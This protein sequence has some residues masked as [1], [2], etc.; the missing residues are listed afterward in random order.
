MSRLPERFYDREPL[1]VAPELLGKVL[2]KDGIRLRITEV[3]AYCGP[4]D[5]AA[6]SR[7]GQT[8]RNAPMWG[9]PGRVY[10]YVCYGIHQML[11]IVT[12]GPARATAILVRACE[13]ADDASLA[14][15]SQRRGGKE[16]PVLLTGPG[17]VG[18]ALAL[19]TSWSHHP[20]FE[21]GGLEL[22]E[23]PAPPGI[24]TGARIGI[25]YAEPS[26]RDAP[27]R[28]AAAETRWVSHLKPL[29]EA[30]GQR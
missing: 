18:Q 27:W 11:N 16:G 9:P 23:G 8:A 29:L 12:Q 19:D 17:K 14:L 26:D 15:V 10:M 25:D 2:V 22:H 6:H 20:L 1:A 13:P 24:L 3:E 7:M 28:F 21:A 5:T 30:A 4:D